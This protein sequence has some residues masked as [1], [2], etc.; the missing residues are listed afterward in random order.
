MI[1]CLG[2]TPVYQRS[3]VFECLT[4]DGVNRAASAHDYASGKSINVARVL[5]TLGEDVIALGF[6]GGRR[7]DAM[8]ADLDAAG[9]R[10]DFVRVATE[11][12]QC[13]TVID[14]STETATEL[15][16]ESKAVSPGDAEA[17]LDKYS[18]S[19]RAARGC[20]LSGSLPP[21]FDDDFYA[22]CL[23]RTPAAI[24]MVLDARGEPLRTALLRHAGFVAKM[25]RDELAATVG[26]NLNSYEEVID[27]ARLGA[28]EGRVY[29]VT[30]GAD[31]ALVVEPGQAWHVI[32]PEV[33]AR[34]AVGS[35]DAFAAGLIAGIVRR[36]SIIEACTWAAAC[37][38]ANAMTDLAGHLSRDD[39][40]SLR[41][42][43]RVER[44]PAGV[45]P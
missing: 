20:V 11:T 45:R 18:D 22:R 37:G 42:R 40:E 4:P 28:K 21:G 8:L 34:S 5:H 15:V 9:I 12:R 1:V 29:I 16:E 44:V 24:P 3:M 17:L 2:T 32:P 39:V 19:V 36:Q 26:G 38:A 13:V 7:G 31:G 41:R 6:A 14:R 35:G 25:N 43:V 30:L 33:A 27:A 10:H 23:D